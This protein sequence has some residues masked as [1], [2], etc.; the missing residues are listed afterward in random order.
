MSSKE[1]YKHVFLIKLGGSV[2]TKRGGDH[3]NFISI[4]KLCNQLSGFQ[5]KVILVHGTGHIGKPPAIKF[6]YTKTKFLP[7]KK[8]NIALKI[9]HKIDQLN[10]AVTKSLNNAGIQA[11]AVDNAVF[12][13]F[14]ENRWNKNGV[15]TFIN[16]LLKNNLTPVLY[17]NFLPQRNGGFHVL[18][19]D[20]LMLALASLI[21][22]AKILFLTDVD[23]VFDKK[24][25]LISLLRKK[26]L[27]DIKENYRD[28]SG[29]MKT[30]VKTALQ[31]KKFCKTCFIANGTRKGILKQFLKKQDIYGTKIFV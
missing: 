7:K 27:S 21:K 10:D 26:D 28:V 18:S 24:G 20:E 11:V 1:K 13:Q 17:G 9:K 16:D 6:E 12:Y 25:K 29:G 4:K 8:T 2:I 23:G 19:S 15:K 14:T 5:D 22:P 3:I 31:I 30:K